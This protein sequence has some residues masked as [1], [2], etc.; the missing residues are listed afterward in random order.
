MSVATRRLASIGG[1][2]SDNAGTVAARENVFGDPR[3]G[4]ARP[5]A[6]P[7][8]VQQRHAVGLQAARHGVEERAV[9]HHADMLEHADR[10]DAV[11]PLAHRAV[12]QQL[13]RYAIRQPLGRR[14]GPR[15]GQLLGRQGDAGDARAVVA[16]QGQR[17]PA[18]AAADVEHVQVRP[19]EAQFGGDVALLGGLRL[20][21]RLV[22]ARE[23]GAGVLPVAVE[24]QA[25]EAPVQIIVMRDIAACARGAGL[26]WSM[27]RL[28][29][30][31]RVRIWATGWPLAL[32]VRLTAATSSTS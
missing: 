5:A 28:T 10:D 27:R 19:I 15:L 30:L 31:I 24:E 1:M 23:V 16:R 20:L 12:V 7:D 9:V 11:E 14:A 8:R 3:I 32:A 22:A 26:Y 17:Q 18:P 4:A 2:T 25:V 21:Q 13:E 6:A 29:V